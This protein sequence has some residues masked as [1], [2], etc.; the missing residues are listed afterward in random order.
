MR[1]IDNTPTPDTTMSWDD[2][3]GIADKYPNFLWGD[4]IFTYLK[5]GQDRNAVRI[6][7]GVTDCFRGYH[8]TPI[9]LDE[10]GYTIMPEFS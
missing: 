6:D 10:A 4:M 7:S 1:L 5:D 2:Y 8:V 3:L 9:E